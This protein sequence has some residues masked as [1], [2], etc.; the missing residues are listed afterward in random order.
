MAR[1]ILEISN[2]PT[3][4]GNPSVVCV[5]VE[6]ADDVHVHYI[7]VQRQGRRIVTDGQGFYKKKDGTFVD[8]DGRFRVSDLE[9]ETYQ[10]D[11]RQRILDCISVRA[12]KV[13]SGQLPK[14][15]EHPD[16]DIIGQRRNDD[17]PEQI[18]DDPDVMA[19]VVDSKWGR[20]VRRVR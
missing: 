3:L 20:K 15:Y 16:N 5:H 12:S 4:P 17:D 9:Y 7:Q 6:A 14:T 10:T 19:L 18:K 11:V 1:Q 8:P 13:Q 2:V